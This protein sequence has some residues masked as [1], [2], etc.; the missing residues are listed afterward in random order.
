MTSLTITQ[1]DAAAPADAV[2]AS[3][4]VPGVFYGPKEASTP[5]VFDRL[6]FDKVLKEAG[7][8]TVVTL[9][10]IGED[11]DTLIHQVD[12]HPV[13]GDPMHVDFYVM[14][15]GKKV[16][17]HV[18][19]EF[20]GEAEAP[21]VKS[22]GGTLMKIIHEIEIEA[23]PKDLPHGITVD[24]SGLDTFESHIAIKDLKLPAG[25]E[26]LMDAEETIVA[27][28]KPREEVEEPVATIDMESIGMSEERGKKEEEGAEG[29]AATEGETKS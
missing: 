14:E 28:G 2:R 9:H 25:V 23:M 21:A 10:G 4:K 20:A 24:V 16:R 11:K 15:K 1:R 12:F 5:I 7:E 26:V 22:L 17:T 27:I 29:A 6:A 18:P 8:S 19:L 3:G 13:T